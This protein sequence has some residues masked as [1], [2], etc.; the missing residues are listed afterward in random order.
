MNIHPLFVH[1]PIA[2][3]V[4][5]VALEIFTPKKDI[6]SPRHL[7]KTILLVAGSIG[8]QFALTT[9][10]MAEQIAGPSAML[11]MHSLFAN[12]TTIVFGINAFI[13]VWDYIIQ[14]WGSILQK[15]KIIHYISILIGFMKKRYL[16]VVL[17]VVGL[18]AVTYTGALGGA[19]VYGSTVD[20]VVHFLIGTL[21]WL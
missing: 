21:P 7:A 12:I 14:K 10:D 2:F 15:Y 1:F 19:M 8:A 18:I 17:A 13:Y 6:S 9:G 5:Y 11:E 4:L 3:F 16:H 20:P